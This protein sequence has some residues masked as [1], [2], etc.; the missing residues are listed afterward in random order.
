MA[1][2]MISAIV[3]LTISILATYYL[4]YKALHQLQQQ[5]AQFNQQVT[6]ALSKQ[7]AALQTVKARVDEPLMNTT[8]HQVNYLIKLAHYQLHTEKNVVAAK[9]LLETALA[10]LTEAAI[11]HS[12]ALEKA[13]QQDIQQLNTVP[14]L[15]DRNTLTTPSAPQ[16]TASHQNAIP[17][18]SSTAATDSTVAYW[19]QRFQIGLQHL[20]NSL[21]QWTNDAIVIGTTPTTLPTIDRSLKALHNM[22]QKTTN[23]KETE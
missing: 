21:K 18:P 5:A 9:Q 11:P 7:A 16:T 4:N 12:T 13:L 3:L 2:V 6:E 19:Q 8:K 20:L 22:Q 15:P 10:Q 23:E 17:S 14:P 1:I